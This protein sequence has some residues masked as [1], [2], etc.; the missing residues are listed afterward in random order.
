MMHLSLPALL[1]RY[2]PLGTRKRRT[3][4]GHIALGV[5]QSLA[6]HVRGVARNSGHHRALDGRGRLAPAARRV[7]GRLGPPVA[8]SSHLL[9]SPA[10]G[11][12]AGGR[13]CPAVQR[14]RRLRAEDG[15]RRLGGVHRTPHRVLRADR[16]ERLYHHPV[17]AVGTR[18]EAA[19]KWGAAAAGGEASEAGAGADHKGVEQAA[20]AEAPGGDAAA[21]AR[22]R[23]ASWGRGRQPCC[24]CEGGGFRWGSDVFNICIGSGN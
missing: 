12:T 9:T 15:G 16:G 19:A 3:R 14:R 20:S 11:E 4:G 24:G 17:V 18:A 5:L 1:A 2:P 10:G 22:T 13:G 6:V 7:V 8:G 21:S 23:V